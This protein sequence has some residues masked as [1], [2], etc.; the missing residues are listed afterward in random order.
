MFSVSPRTVVPAHVLAFRGASGGERRM[1]D[2]AAAP[3]APRPRCLSRRVLSG[4]PLALHV[5][6]RGLGPADPRIVG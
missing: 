6:V 3:H 2:P 1:V 4:W 5:P